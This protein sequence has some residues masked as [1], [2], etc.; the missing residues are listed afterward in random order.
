M[1]Q[2]EHIFQR[3]LNAWVRD[4][5]AVEHL[6]LSRDAAKITTVYGRAKD[7]ARGMVAGD[8]DTCLHVLE[9]PAIYAELKAPGGK[10][11]EA[12]EY[13]STRLMRLGCY[14]SYVTSVEQYRLWIAAIGVPLV[15]NAEYQA[16]QADAKIEAA[17]AKAAAKKPARATKPARTTK[18]TPRY[19]VG[20]RVAS[21]AARA[22]IRL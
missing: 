17:I 10:P 18:P 8:P 2:R 6:F 11:S 19:T 4:C 21:R 20:K 22:G 13:I 15:T 3:Y 7:K 5:V 16:M 12:Q 9:F 14:W 1:I